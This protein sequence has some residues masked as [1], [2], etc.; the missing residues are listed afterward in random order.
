MNYVLLIFACLIGI[1]SLIIVLSSFFQKRREGFTW[2]NYLTQQFLEIQQTQNPGIVFDPE[3]IQK[4]ES[5]D[6]LKYFIKHKVWP[7]S[8]DT[9]KLYVEALNKNPYVRTDPINA[10]KTIRSIYNES[11]IL[12]ILSWQAKEGRFLLEG[13]SV[14]D[15]IN[16]LPNGW[17]DFAYNSRQIK[18]E[19]NGIVYK[20]AYDSNGII[21]MVK[22]KRLGVDGI[23][24]V[25]KKETTPIRDIDLEEALPGFQFI[26]EPCN[27]CEALNNPPNYNCPFTLETSGTIGGKETS[28][29]WKYLWGV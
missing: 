2:N 18:R 10:I 24:G 13:V 9:E 11:S 7:W 19:N 29:I 6:E 3:Q 27:P 20:C 4:Q 25:E 23:T 16:L 5:Q 28:A 14:I 22:V 8:K 1:I 12:E 26:N 15:N 21:S 17:G